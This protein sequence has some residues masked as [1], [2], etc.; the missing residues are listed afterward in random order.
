MTNHDDGSK[1]TSLSSQTAPS[2]S[3]SVLLNYTNSTITKDNAD[4]ASTLVT[5][6][7]RASQFKCTTTNSNDSRRTNPIPLS[8][9]TSTS[10]SVS[11]PLLSL[12]LTSVNGNDGEHRTSSRKRGRHDL[13]QAS[14]SCKVV[15]YSDT[16]GGANTPH[17]NLNEHVNAN[18][19]IN[20]NT[21][22]SRIRE[23]SIINS[24][25]SNLDNLRKYRDKTGAFDFPEDGFDNDDIGTSGTSTWN[26]NTN[27][28]KYLNLKR[29]VREQRQQYRS[30]I[31]GHNTEMSE[32][33]MKLLSNI[34]F[35]FD[36]VQTTTRT[37]INEISRTSNITCAYKTADVR[38]AST[39]A[40]ASAVG[41]LGLSSVSSNKRQR[42]E[43]DKT[44]KKWV[45]MF[46]VLQTYHATHGHC[47]VIKPKLKRQKIGVSGGSN[48]RSIGSDRNMN[49]ISPKLTQIPIGAAALQPPGID[50][51]TANTNRNSKYM[52]DNDKALFNWVTIQRSEYRKLKKGAPNR[53]TAQRMQKLHDLGFNFSKRKEYLRWPDRLEQLRQY[54]VKHGHLNISVTDVELGEFVGRTRVEYAKYIDGN[55][56]VGMN[57]ERV[58]ELT[59]LGFIFSAG[60]RRP[61]IKDKGGQLMV[62][63]K[64]T[65]NE[66]FEELV[67]YKSKHGHCLVPQQSRAGL[68]EWVHK[69]RTNY[70]LL[71]AGKK[72]PMRAEMALKLTEE[73]FVFDASRHRKRTSSSTNRNKA[74]L[75]EQDQ[76]QRQQQ[77]VPLHAP[78]DLSIDNNVLMEFQR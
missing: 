12:P 76:Q 56:K 3:A 27:I 65:W 33:K 48:S 24:W 55:K 21:S 49:E 36:S 51:I 52:V 42:L 26:A 66:R 4:A 71:R 31:L 17:N 14:V 35:L 11:T 70:K 53:L 44:N 23:P 22:V 28:P 2:V 15:E 61:R 77:D 47:D 39:T 10:T 18:V 5:E 58:R 1:N 41:E 75:D 50:A 68:G 25:L 20:V 69:Q 62:A 57:E 43:T 74:A 67:K 60:K 37:A 6:L 19:N 59:T 8:S 46:A 73:G 34:G 64:R 9:S 45:E 38:N 16:A 13:T 78:M 54:K 30:Y 32:E 7:S 63:Q 40:S 72:S 29:W